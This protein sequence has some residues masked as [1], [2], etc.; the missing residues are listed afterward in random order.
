MVSGLS[1]I[2]LLGTSNL[3]WLK[4]NRES[5]WSEG[6]VPTSLGIRVCPRGRGGE[7]EDMCAFHFIEKHI[8]LVRI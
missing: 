6:E 7:E 4:R 8:C 5:G 1:Q 2:I 3:P